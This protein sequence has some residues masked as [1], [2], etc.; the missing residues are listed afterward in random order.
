MKT[1]CQ[2]RIKKNYL[3]YKFKLDYR[4][5]IRVKIYIEVTPKGSTKLR[6]FLRLFSIIIYQPPRVDKL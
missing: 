5:E 2:I 4:S 6:Y 3:P 1:N